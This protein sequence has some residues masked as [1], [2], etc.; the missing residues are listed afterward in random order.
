MNEIM[1]RV[2]VI[3]AIAAFAFVAKADGAPWKI[4]KG[5][6]LFVTGVVDCVELDIPDGVERIMQ[7]SFE[8]CDTIERVYFPE[9]LV[10]IHAF[11]FADCSRLMELKLPES[12]SEIYLGAFYGC[13][14]LVSVKLPDALREIRAEVFMGCSSLREIVLPA[15]ITNIGEKAFANCKSLCRVY[16]KSGMNCSKAATAFANCPS[17]LEFIQIED[18]TNELQFVEVELDPNGGELDERTIRTVY[19]HNYGL[20]P[21]PE[22]EGFAF[23]GWWTAVEG[24]SK[25]ISTTKVV[26]D[27]FGTLY[28][29]WRKL[30]FGEFTTGGDAEWSQISDDVWESG[31]IGDINGGKSSWLQKEVDGKGT[32]TFEWF[33]SDNHDCW[34]VLDFYVDGKKCASANGSTSWVDASHEIDAIG[35]HSL[36]WVFAITVGTLDEDPNYACVR[37][38]AWMPKDNELPEDVEALGEIAFADD[39]VATVIGGDAEKYAKFRTWANAVEGGASAA[40]TSRWAAVSYLL[41]ANKLFG[42][43]PLLE[44]RE[45]ALVDAT[46]GDGRDFVVAMQFFDGEEAREVSA[47]SVADL[48][49][50]TD[51]VRDWEEHGG[52]PLSVTPKSSGMRSRHSFRIAPSDANAPRAFLRVNTRVSR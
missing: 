29:H 24:G 43:E 52:K 25:V 10:G 14:A 36:K 45:C 8:Y 48:F 23:D 9:S 31:K 41:G 7:N 15:G 49:E 47:E 37:N 19:G 2:L 21:T 38:I 33:V 51:D 40:V 4:E 26:G 46:D 1:R 50:V 20:L 11:A 13:K 44:I 12:V 17:C 32:L 22:R 42:N 34:Y 39:N 3:V 35:H 18:D 30:E 28:A 5:G 27:N 6:Q 16:E